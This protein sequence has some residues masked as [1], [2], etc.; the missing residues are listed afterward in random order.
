MVANGYWL[1][2]HAA[3]VRAMYGE[4]EA[5]PTL[6]RSYEVEERTSSAYVQIDMHVRR[7]ILTRRPACVT[8]R[9]STPIEFNDLVAAGQPETTRREPKSTISCPR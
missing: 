1:Q 6:V 4:P 9:S 3:E 8:R 5:G 7:E 2:D